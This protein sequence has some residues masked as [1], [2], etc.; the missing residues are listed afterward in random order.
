VDQR[1]AGISVSVLIQPVN[2]F[3]I[4]HLDVVHNEP[5][6]CLYYSTQA[7]DWTPQR[8]MIS[9]TGNIYRKSYCSGQWTQCLAFSVGPGDLKFIPREQI[10]NMAIAVNGAV[11][12]VVK[13]ICEIWEF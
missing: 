4:Y 6:S 1:Q 12:L 5:L 11:F 3:H 10:K 7:C 2:F 13:F 9:V 8:V